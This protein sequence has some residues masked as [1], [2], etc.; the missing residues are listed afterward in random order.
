MERERDLHPLRDHEFGLDVI[1][2]QC[3]TLQIIDIA[4]PPNRSSFP[5]EAREFMHTYYFAQSCA[6]ANVL[7]NLEGTIYVEDLIIDGKSIRKKLIEKKWARES[8]SQRNKILELVSLAN[9]QAMKTEVKKQDSFS[10]VAMQAPKKRKIIQY[11]RDELIQMRNNPVDKEIIYQVE[12]SGVELRNS[13]EAVE[14]PLA[15][16]TF[17]ETTVDDED[18][19]EIISDVEHDEAA[20][21]IQLSKGTEQAPKKPVSSEV[22]SEMID[23]QCSIS[24][25]DIDVHGEPTAKIEELVSETIEGCEKIPSSQTEESSIDERSLISIISDNDQ[26]GDR[27]EKVSDAIAQQSLSKEVKEALY[28]LV[29]VSYAPVTVETVDSCTSTELLNILLLINEKFTDEDFNSDDPDVDFASLKHTLGFFLD[30]F[31]LLVVSVLKQMTNTQLLDKNV[32]GLLT[33][34]NQIVW[35]TAAKLK[36]RQSVVEIVDILWERIGGGAN[37]GLNFDE[38]YFKTILPHWLETLVHGF[39]QRNNMDSVETDLQFLKK[40]YRC[41][42]HPW[43]GVFNDKALSMVNEIMFNFCANRPDDADKFDKFTSAVLTN[44]IVPFLKHVKR[45]NFKHLIQGSNTF[46]HVE[47]IVTQFLKECLTD[48]TILIL[49]ENLTTLRAMDQYLGECYLNVKDVKFYQYN[50]EYQAQFLTKIIK[51]VEKAR[52]VEYFLDKAE[53]DFE[54]Y[55]DINSDL[56]QKELKLKW[57]EHHR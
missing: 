16:I 13:V 55:D 42:A 48:P 56:P 47:I 22:R 20:S 1:A 38:D 15:T 50:F 46:Q 30:D 51:E 34:I 33:A 41:E 54:E 44:W 52:I 32:K 6:V 25:F 7:G 19:F 23:H 49:I 57:T 18:E 43:A 29:E 4:P 21:Q 11:D 27:R 14:G 40:M 45:E 28:Q 8:K 53:I 10:A 35:Y 26:S 24:M 9:S 31:V 12:K 3:V 39:Y 36:N 5:D 2:P 37:T 17:E